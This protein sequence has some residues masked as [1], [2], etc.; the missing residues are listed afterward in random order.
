MSNNLKPSE[1]PLF[2][3]FFMNSDLQDADCETVLRNIVSIQKKLNEN[4]LT[5]EWK[6]FSWDDYVSLC[7]HNPSEYEKKILQTFVSGGRVPIPYATQIV[8]G[9]RLGIE[10]ERYFLTEKMFVTFEDLLS[11]WDSNQQK[12]KW[13]KLN[14]PLTYLVSGFFY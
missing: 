14:N 11:E 3:S 2:S 5:D 13:L 10:N 7:S 4:D 9:G 6:Q 1:I 8:S 12:K